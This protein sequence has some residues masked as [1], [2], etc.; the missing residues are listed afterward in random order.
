MRTLKSIFFLCIALVV[1][2]SCEMEN[3]NSEVAINISDS[4][5]FYEKLL[6]EGNSGV[7]KPEDALK[8][9]KYYNA[10]AN[11]NKLDELSPSYLFKAADIYMNMNE[12][13]D[14][15]NCFDLLMTNYPKN[16]KAISSL[17]LKA[18]VYEDQLADYVNAEKYYIMFLE[19]YPDSDFADDAQISLNN[20]GKT[21]E[22]LIE[23]FENMNK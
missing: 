5:S 6:F 23:E 4:I 2:N 21:P 12:A 13:K 17:F 18:F 11:N 3:S 1:F 9:A 22:Q 8:L 16:D 19:K 15:I 7:I 14:A 20:L 10:Y